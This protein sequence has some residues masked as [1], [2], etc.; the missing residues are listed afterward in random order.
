MHE[1]DYKYSDSKRGPN[2]PI[3][4]VHNSGSL[5]GAGM[6]LFWVVLIV[7]LFFLFG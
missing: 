3:H 4:K 2:F 7:I 5:C 6:P 1:Y